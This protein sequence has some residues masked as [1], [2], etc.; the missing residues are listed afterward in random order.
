MN[1]L[2]TP[3]LVVNDARLQ[4]LCRHWATLPVI[5][6]D[7]EFIRVNTFYPKPG[8][9]QVCDD[10]GV[11]LL[12]PL[13]IR[14]WGGFIDLLVDTGVVKIL[15]SASED[16]VLFQHYFDCIP[17]PLF[18]T[19]KAAA[20]LGYGYSISYLNL[21]WKLT[22]TELSKGETR[23]DWLKRPLSPN[24]LKYA[25]LDVAYLPEI[26]QFLRDEL[27]QKK[28][29]LWLQQE[30]ERMRQITRQ[31]EDETGWPFLYQN[32][33][34]AWRLNQRQLGAL[35]ELSLWREQ[36]CRFRDKPRSWIGRDADL[37]LLAEKMP[38]NRTA[39]NQL[40]DMSRNI[41]QQDADTLLAIIAESKPVSDAEMKDVVGEPM[42]AEQRQTLKKCQKAVRTIADTYGMAEE[43]I[44]RKK[45]LIK[46]VAQAGQ[47]ELSWP[48]DI[49]GWQRSLLEPALTKVLQ[50]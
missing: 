19:Q 21:V 17:G 8:L 35:K 2:S 32:M 26:Y 6:L 11:F 23:S 40:Q 46:F 39:L 4:E 9:I 24:Q 10:Q 44:A 25:A 41:Y 13:S 14:Q 15:H 42:S 48:S 5:A 50:A 47:P 38:V 1:D 36:Q 43:L 18:D 16:L 7:T 12:D 20:F 34:A 45:H 29:L 30:C 27:D 49:E 37:I 3:E 28:R 22:G 33:G 31:I